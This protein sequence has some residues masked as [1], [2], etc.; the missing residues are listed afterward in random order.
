[1]LHGK[2]CVHL[3]SQ[4]PVSK[5]K[6]QHPNSCVALTGYLASLIILP[7][8][9]KMEEMTDDPWVNGLL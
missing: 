9:Q 1:M 5:P 4:G 8:M 7:L 2:K 3:E 6:I